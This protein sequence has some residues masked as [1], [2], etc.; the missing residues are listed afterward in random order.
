MEN[1]MAALRKE[2]SELK[3]KSLFS[4]NPSGEQMNTTTSKSVK[5]VTKSIISPTTQKTATSL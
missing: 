1:M 2:F 5:E 3:K 4:S